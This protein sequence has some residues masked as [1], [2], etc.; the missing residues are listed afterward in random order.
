MS[1]SLNLEKGLFA[2]VSDSLEIEKIWKSAFE[3]R[4]NLLGKV[5]SAERL[6]LRPE[7]RSKTRLIFSFIPHG[8]ASEKGSK[9][10]VGQFS[11]GG[12]MY[13]FHGTGEV[14][15][16][17]ISLSPEIPLFRVQRRQN[18]RVKVPPQFR[19]SLKILKVEEHPL[20]VS[21]ALFDLSAGGCC[22]QIPLTGAQLTSNT[23]FSGIL[24]LQNREAV[25]VQGYV[26]HIRELSVNQTKAKLVGIQFQP[27][28]PSL[29]SLL[30]SVTMELSRHYLRSA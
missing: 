28:T 10:V 12:E 2:K 22:L 1:S 7:I 3:N 16:H 17:Q 30:F 4:T 27:L 6:N 23:R 9:D 15:G 11:V 18:Y 26:R 24:D 8:T 14:D 19:S 29:E 20:N 21:F 25:E 5:G 13:F